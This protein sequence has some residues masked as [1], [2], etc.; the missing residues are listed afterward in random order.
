MHLSSHDVNE[1][2][3][4]GTCRNDGTANLR[5][6]SMSRIL[7]NKRLSELNHAIAL[8]PEKVGAA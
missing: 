3:H 7:R 2:M 4:P 1:T 8:V 6:A 5:L